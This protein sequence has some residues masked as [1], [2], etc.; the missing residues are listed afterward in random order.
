[1]NPD[2]LAQALVQRGGYNPTD[3]ANAARGPRAQELAKEFGVG[4]STP[5][6]S[7]PQVT[8]G[9]SYQASSSGLPSEQA[10]INAMTQ[11]GHSVETA[12]AAIAGRGV[13][14]LARE[15]L[16]YSPNAGS[17]VTGLLSNN[18]PIN[19]P[20]LY[21]SLVDTSGIK[22][23]EEDYFKKEQELN[24]NISLINDNPFLSEA[25]RVGRIQKIQTDFNNATA[26]QQ[27]QI[28]SKKADIETQLNLQTKQFDINSQ[29]AQLALSQFS[30]L[31]DA[32]ALNTANDEDVANLTRATGLS[33][34]I[35]RSAIQNKVQ[36]GYAT[37]IQSFDDGVDEG[38]VIYTIDPLGNIVNQTKQVTGKST[39]AKSLGM[40][41]T[42]PVVSSFLSQYLNRQTNISDLWEGIY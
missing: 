4:Q 22:A 19:L 28:E 13:A 32:G 11:K 9:T 6:Q 29:Q 33:S 15:Y 27:R 10:L 34:N 41:S 31:L 39:K 30:S 5:Q 17:G 16:G 40:Y 7:A 35:I 8:A 20:E 23:L 1:M 36:A 2:Q 18:P 26:T 38:F 21:K 3:A 37:E 12:K 25:N 24:K 42:D 14:D